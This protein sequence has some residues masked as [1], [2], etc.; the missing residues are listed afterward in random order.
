MPA[1]LTFPELCRACGKPSVYVRNLQASLDLP[2]PDGDRL[3]SPAYLQ[4]I[5]IIISLRTFSVPLE[6]IADLLAKE[7]VVLRLLKVDA[8]GS[9]PT[10]YLDQCGENGNPDRRL[11]LT[12]YDVG[13]S[14]AGKAIQ[15]NLDFGL[16]PKEL[17]SDR[18]MGEDVRR[19]VDDYLKLSEKIMTRVER[20][21]PILNRALNWAKKNTKR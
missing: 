19:A 18:E 9:S 6:D 15:P 11:M 3:Y 14:I 13:F 2:L 1:T 4:I 21:R 12:G 8:L 16:R 7:L 5:Q 17:F 10:W 20:E